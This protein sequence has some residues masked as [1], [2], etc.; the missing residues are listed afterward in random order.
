MATTSTSPLACEHDSSRGTR[1][2][3]SPVANAW[4]CDACGHLRPFTDDDYAFCN[5]QPWTP[6]APE[7][8]QP[9]AWLFTSREA[10][11]AHYTALAA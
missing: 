6:R 7:G 9:L 2:D 4:E 3:D 8:V 1:T 10:R 5:A 11:F